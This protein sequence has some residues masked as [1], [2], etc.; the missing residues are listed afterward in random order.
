MSTSPKATHV[1]YDLR[2]DGKTVPT[3]D[4]KTVPTWVTVHWGE[5]DEMQVYVGMTDPKKLD[6]EKLAQK[7]ER[8]LHR[9]AKELAK[10]F[11]ESP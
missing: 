1:E 11:V 4:G 3:E 2:E 10:T 7:A 6:R 9:I 5:D 8:E